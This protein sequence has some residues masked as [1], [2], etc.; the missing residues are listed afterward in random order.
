MEAVRP[1]GAGLLDKHAQVLRERVQS[2]S[3]LENR[4]RVSLLEPSPAEGRSSVSRAASARVRQH[5]GKQQQLS[6]RVEEAPRIQECDDGKLA[7]GAF[8]GH[9]RLLESFLLSR[10]NG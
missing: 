6:G 1:I 5:L 9:L 7:K 8:H 3:L 4:I 10:L 2:H